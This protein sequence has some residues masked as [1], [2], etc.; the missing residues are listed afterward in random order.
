MATNEDEPHVRWRGGLRN[1]NRRGDLSKVR[2]CGAMTRR[3]TACAQPAM[4]NRRRRMHSGTST[5][6][7]QDLVNIPVLILTGADGAGKH[8]AALEAVRAIEKPFDPDRVLCAVRRALP[9]E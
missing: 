7:N 3:R 2:R 1:E 6:P 9:A 5:V 8:A 4:L